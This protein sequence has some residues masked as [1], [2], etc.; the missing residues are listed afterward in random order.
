MAAVMASGV[1]H[2][3]Y[4]SLSEQWHYTTTLYYTLYVLLC[5]INELLC[6]VGQFFFSLK[7]STS[8][9]I[10]RTA[11]IQDEAWLYFFTILVT[12]YISIQTCRVFFLA[13]PV[14]VSGTEDSTRRLPS[15]ALFR[16]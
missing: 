10:N 8:I 2:D 14:I 4:Q 3:K 11:E 15:I 16:V 1:S 6:R 5:S 13:V 12:I 9:E 7:D